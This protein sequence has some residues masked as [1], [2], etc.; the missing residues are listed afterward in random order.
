MDIQ[1]DF[2]LKKYNSF[3]IEAKAKKFVSA[4]SVAE[5][6]TI[7]IENKNQQKFIL[8]GGSNMLLTQDI[9]SL[10]IHIDLK[11]REIIK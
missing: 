2:S 3:G 6:K 4:Q 10:V 5:L 8:G 9:D 1:F 7:L 11:G